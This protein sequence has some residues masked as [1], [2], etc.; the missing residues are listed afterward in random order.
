MR[1]LLCSLVALLIAAPLLLVG[2]G[3][4][5]AEVRAAGTSTVRV[6]VLV[7]GR[8]LPEYS[9]RR[10]TYIEALRGKEYSIRLSNDSPGR[11]AVALSV[12]GLN[13]ID[14][15]RS[16]AY[17]ASKWVIAP[18]DSVTVRGW[19]VGSDRARQ[20]VF[21]SEEKSYG[22]WLG[23]TRN[24]GVISAVFFAEEP[25]DDCC[26]VVPFTGPA[27]S[28][29]L[30][31]D[32]ESLAPER[33]RSSSRADGRAPRGDRGSS[34]G[35]AA[36]REAPRAEESPSAPGRRSGSEVARPA[37]KKKERA[38]TGTGRRLRHQV[39]WVEFV[40]AESPLA[41]LDLRYGFRDE[42]VELGVLPEAVPDTSLT[43]RES[44][45]GF[46]PD[47]GSSCCR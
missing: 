16:T 29:R 26:E 3:L 39:E 5:P 23:E 12:D 13:T 1:T 40:L 22:T 36:D 38:A 46:A 45:T 8:V 2:D 25:R 34:A 6:E 35:A 21:T 7:D 17:S 19:Q 11:V 41:E 42:L 20:F 10:A 47:P 27:D 24:L 14:A 18:G 9:K 37:P 44:A 30:E 28:D 33:P 31:D 4:E 43:R 15:K 32:T